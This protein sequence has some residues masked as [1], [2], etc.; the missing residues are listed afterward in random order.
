MTEIRMHDTETLF[1]Y[2]VMTFYHNQLP[3]SQCCLFSLIPGT[4]WGARL[5]YQYCNNTS[6]SAVFLSV[7]IK[8]L[9]T[10]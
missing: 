5:H 9:L 10:F 1:K 8:A 4:V 2:C 6:N 7:G 3:V